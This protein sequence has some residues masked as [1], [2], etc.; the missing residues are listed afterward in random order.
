VV[1]LVGWPLNSYVA[2]R[3]VRMH[4]GELKARDGRMSV[5]NELIGAVRF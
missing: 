1:L 2:R 5:V 3:R 4:K